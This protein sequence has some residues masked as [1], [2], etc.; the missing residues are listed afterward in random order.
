MWMGLAVAVLALIGLAR[1]F[2]GYP[3][4][5]RAWK[6]LAPREAA[7]VAAAA[8]ATFPAGGAIPPSGRDAGV[9]AY[10]DRWLAGMR[11]LRRSVFPEDR[12]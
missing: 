9:D 1:I 2:A 3:R 6:V 10:V 5:A 8:E 11:R 7:L 4:P 12:G